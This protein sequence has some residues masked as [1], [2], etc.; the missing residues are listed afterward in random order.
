MSTDDTTGGAEQFEI[1]LFADLSTFDELERKIVTIVQNVEDLKAENHK[2]RAKADK[3]ENE[4]KR[5]T[6][7]IQLLASKE[8]DLRD[9]Q[10]DVQKEKL[11]RQRLQDLLKKLEGI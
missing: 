11:I 2:L 1:G 7:E 8:R 4:L 6:E 10:R 5:K 3:L 9:N